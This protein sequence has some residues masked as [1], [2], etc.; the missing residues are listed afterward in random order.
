[1]P[2]GAAPEARIA[3]AI[4]ALLFIAMLIGGGAGVEHP[5]TGAVI[6]SCAVAILLLS[7]CAPERLGLAVQP[8]SGLA[9]LAL[10]IPL[11][12]LLVQLVPL[13]ASLAAG[14]PG[15]DLARDLLA[16]AGITRIWPSLSLNPVASASTALELLPGVA[17]FVLACRGGRTMRATLIEAYLVSAVIALLLGLFQKLGGASEALGSVAGVQSDQSRGFFVNRNHQAS[18]LLI[19]MP[20][21]ALWAS[22]TDR[23]SGAQEKLRLLLGWGLAGIFA[24]GVIA[25]LSRT[26]FLL[27]ALAGVATFLILNRERLS[28]RSALIAMVPLALICAFAS[29]ASIVQDTLARFTG[30][31]DGRTQFLENTATAARGFWP[32]GSGL[33]TFVDIYPAFEPAEQVS[34][35]Y[36]NNAHNDYAEL[37]MEGGLAA[38]IAFAATLVLIGWGFARRFSTSSDASTKAAATAALA[39]ILILLLHSIVDYPLRMMALVATAGLLLA[40]LLSDTE[41]RERSGARSRGVLSAIAACAALALLWPVWQFALSDQAVRDKAFDR[42]LAHNSWSVEALA[43]AGYQALGAQ[44][45][46]RALAFAQRAMA[47]APLDARGVALLISTKQATGDEA[48]ADRLLTLATKLGWREAHIQFALATRAAVRDEFPAAI[49]HIDALLRTGSYV[50]IMMPYTLSLE[51]YPAALP[52]LVAALARQPS[53][54]RP[55]LTQLDQLPLAQAAAHLEVL[56]GLARSAAPPVP[57]EIAALVSYHIARGDYAMAITVDRSFAPANDGQAGLLS[58]RALAQLPGG[59]GGVSPFGWRT[60]ATIG[61]A[62]TVDEK[63]A[64]AVSSPRATTG[65]ALT[66][67]IVAQPGPWTLNG[68][69]RQGSEG[70][71]RAFNWTL[72]CLPSGALVVPEQGEDKMQGD[73]SIAFS[74]HFIIPAQGCGAQRLVLGLDTPG[75][76]DISIVQLDSRP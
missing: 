42:A 24:I 46:V 33:G 50:D 29:Q 52:P 61:I 20:L 7:L 8:L 45:N 48:G 3:R 28:P 18:F 12:F 40:M 4:I 72:R 66:R 49:A 35:A 65:P 26:G 73:G 67:L 22:T 15:R 76:V 37:W 16:T 51:E 57:E 1:M 55:F 75:A 43:K 70:S 64:I 59:K 58:A 23:L 36:V 54:R 39:G 11:V 30:E 68:T 34:F 27:I 19:A 5:L 13:P 44:D 56:R 9:R 47:I 41:G 32:A 53:W 6:Q 38:L 17:I 74:R 71:W 31:A 10:L 69:A 2:A 21:A 60:P 25:T 14:L 63:G 62:A